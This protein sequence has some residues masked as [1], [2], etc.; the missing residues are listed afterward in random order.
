MISFYKMLHLAGV[1]SAVLLT[2][3]VMEK[4]S[5]I[6]DNV[7]G[8]TSDVDGV[9]CGTVYEPDGMHP[10]QGATVVIRPCDYLPENNTLGKKI[11]ENGYAV[12]STTT[13]DSGYY[14]FTQADSIPEKLFIIEARDEKNNCVL[15]G[16]VVIDSSLYYDNA[17]RKLPRKFSDTLKAP[18]TIQGTVQPVRD[19]INAFVRV[20]GLN[21]SAAVDDNGRFVLAMIPQGKFRMQCSVLSGGKSSHDTLQVA[22]KAGDTA[23]ADT[24]FIVPEIN[25]TKGSDSTSLISTFIKTFGGDQDDFGKSVRQTSDGGYIVVGATGSFG[26]GDS[27]VYLIKT[28][29][30]GNKIWTKTFGGAKE[31]LGDCVQQTGDGGYIIVGSTSSYGA[32]GSDAYLI[33]TDALGNETWTKTF[34]GVRDDWGY[35]VQQTSDGGYIISGSTSSLV[36]E[37]SGLY[38]DLCLIK[39]DGAGNETWIKTFGE[40][41]NDFG[42]SV[43]QTSDGGYIVAGYTFTLGPVLNLIKTDSAGNETWT[44]TFSEAYSSVQQ[45]SDG[46]YIITGTTYIH[47]H[48]GN[49]AL[50]HKTDAAGNTT[51]IKTF[52]PDTVDQWGYPAWLT[53]DGR[54]VSASSNGCEGRQ[55]SDG[56]Y[57]I[58]GWTNSKDDEYYDVYLIKTDAAGNETWSKSFGGAHHDFGYSVRQASDG[59]YIITGKY[60]SSAGG[61]LDV[62][63][64]KTDENGD[65]K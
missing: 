62:Y 51:W 47:G 39:T 22:V 3:C 53:S 41:M 30:L 15:I 24:L 54:Y 13:N 18:G 65:V 60:D 50:L 38:P 11:V 6:G 29:P 52:G 37:A 64:I 2:G 19:S 48:S 43:Q 4:P 12:W 55:T 21:A 8:S 9:V 5:G 34:G 61:G 26:A 10:A 31:D 23:Q 58:T 25:G 14:E 1:I 40:D 33:K 20:F 16:N 44:K 32:G 59:G 49:Y 42:V 45:T 56:G 28:D 17:D 27:D 36:A 7:G 46:G 35:C 57:I 63:L